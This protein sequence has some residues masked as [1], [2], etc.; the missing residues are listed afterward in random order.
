MLNMIVEVGELGKPL[1]R[2]DLLAVAAI[3][4]ASFPFSR[5]KELKGRIKNG[6]PGRGW[7]R[8]FLKRY[9]GELTFKKSH[10][11]E[12]CRNAAHNAGT[13]MTHISKIT[14]IIER[15][16]SD[17]SKIFNVDE[18]GCGPRDFLRTHIKFLA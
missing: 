15:Q 3:L 8:C 14:R 11:L 6:K 5:Q 9:K 4:I 7:A 17:A 12:C 2:G 18:I 13:L 1:S 16:N 10:H